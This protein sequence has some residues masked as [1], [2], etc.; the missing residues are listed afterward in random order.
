MGHLAVRFPFVLLLVWGGHCFLPIQ[1]SNGAYDS[2]DS[3]GSRWDA[4]PRVINGNERSL[5]GG[6]RFSVSG[7]SYEAFRDEFSWSSE[8]DV[9][10][11]QQAVDDAFNAWSSVDPNSG[12]A[13]D[14]RFQSDLTTEIQTGSGFGT[15]NNNGAEID[16]IASNSGTAGFFGLTA[17]SRFATPVTLTSGVSN[18]SPS[19]AIQGVDLH[20]NSHPDTEY[21]L[22]IFRRLLTHEIGHALGLGDVDLGGQFLD[23]NYDPSNPLET[24]TN[25]WAS[26]VDPLDP[27]SSANLQF[28]DV[29]PA[30]FQ[31]T[32]V[33][34]LM[35]SNQLGV[36]P[37][38]PLSERVP[39]RN[40]DYGSRQFLYPFVS[41]VPEPNG[42]SLLLF[43]VLL[44]MAKNRVRR[45]DISL[46]LPSF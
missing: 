11:F 46:E 31:T 25:S 7:G 8:P 40:S 39:L 18:Y 22:D 19:A 38:N 1:S 33:D 10:Q 15:L 28:F 3:L 44:A 5:D 23:D 6:L 41:P 37:A 12:L 35:E 34:I 9:A 30:M 45:R 42:L 26:F 20:L 36:S 32:G 21:T 17:V 4:A 14:L 43:V 13:T 27:A 2:I 29:D 24:L 16:L